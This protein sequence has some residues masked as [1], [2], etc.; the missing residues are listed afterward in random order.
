MRK[1]QK[2]AVVAA[3]VGSVGIVGAGTAV[4]GGGHGGGGLAINQS[5]NCKS[6][7]AN[8][9]VL[10]NIGVLNG[11]AGNAVNGEG[12]PGATVFSQGSTMGCNN[13]VGG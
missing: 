8:V 10:S 13:V 12:A 6:H 3:M 1:L 4:A 7:D 9:S 5:A 11:L 2:L